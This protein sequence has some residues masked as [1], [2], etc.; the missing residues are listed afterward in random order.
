MAAV[1]QFIEAQNGELVGTA[2][3]ARLTLAGAK[4]TWEL[5]DGRKLTETY[6]ST[7]LAASAYADYKAILTGTAAATPRLISVSPSYIDPYM[8]SSEGVRVTATGEGFEAGY[9]VGSEG[10]V[11]ASLTL[12]EG[13]TQLYED[14]GGGGGAV[15]VAAIGVYDM[16]LYSGDGT[17]LDRLV[18]AL[19]IGPARTN[20][21]FQTLLSAAPTLEMPT[22][23][24]L[25]C[26]W[27]GSTDGENLDTLYKWN[28]TSQQ[29]DALI[30]AE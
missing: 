27:Q 20:P 7:V 29:W 4:V 16:I 19:T 10:A 28:K 15:P 13:T 14:F 30:A 1:P 24:T 18:N 8:M 22:I 3:V 21:D 25:D 5:T 6:G 17:E 12:M 9:Y 26:W 2:Q 23:P 11:I